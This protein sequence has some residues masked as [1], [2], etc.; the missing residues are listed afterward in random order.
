MMSFEN[1][2]DGLDA[3]NAK[4]KSVTED[5]RK[6][7]GRFSLRKA[8]QVIRDAARENA[9]RLDDPSTPSA[10]PENIVERWNNRLYKRR[11]DIGF[12]IGVRGGAR[13][14]KEDYADPKNTAHWRFVEFGTSKAAARPFMRPA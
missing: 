11:G 8:A 9:K 7:G 5:V 2:Y 10:I 4:L 13:A 3:L 14:T 12:R 1:K 6:R